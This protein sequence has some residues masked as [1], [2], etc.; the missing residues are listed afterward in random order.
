[1]Y[2]VYKIDNGL[3]VPYLVNANTFEELVDILLQDGNKSFRKEIREV[4]FLD[5]DSE[6]KLQAHIFLANIDN[7]I[8][9]IKKEYSVFLEDEPSLRIFNTADGAIEYLKFKNQIISKSCETVLNY[10]QKCIDTLKDSLIQK[11][12]II[13][14]ESFIKDMKK[15]VKK[16]AKKHNLVIEKSDCYGMK[17]TYTKDDRFTDY[18]GTKNFL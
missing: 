4:W 6:S 8:Q 3:S 1:M 2:K 17:L 7:E 16:Y 5:F 11:D 10:E 18:L 9:I 12:F 13:E 14:V 15:A